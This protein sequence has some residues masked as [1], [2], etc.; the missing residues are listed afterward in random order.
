M[1]YIITESKI[2]KFVSSYLNGQ[3]WYTLDIGDDEF[4]VIDD[5]DETPK[6][7]FRISHSS[8]VP[9]LGFDML[10]IDDDFLMK[11]VNLFNLNVR[12][13]AQSI[14]NWFNEKYNKNLTERDWEWFMKDDEDYDDN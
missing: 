1:R 9:H 8:T 12:D 10:Y 3:N 4:D 2:N 7:K 14:I 5:D 11:M 13:A 6:L